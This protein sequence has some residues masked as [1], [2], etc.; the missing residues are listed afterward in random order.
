MSAF[1]RRLG[2]LDDD[3]EAAVRDEAKTTMAQAVTDMESIEQPDQSILFEHV[4]ATGSPWTF[5]EGL[6]ELRA[7]ERP[8]AVKPIG[9]Q[10]TSRGTGE[11]DL[12]AEPAQ[13]TT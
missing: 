5:T 11:H 3:K 2:V 7:V 13:E 4:Y 6:E 10:P 12:P 9:P 1:L 8:P